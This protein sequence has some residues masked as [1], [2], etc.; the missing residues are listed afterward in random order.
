M[1]RSALA[2]ILVS[3]TAFATPMVGA[4]IGITQDQ[5]NSTQ[6][7]N[8]TYSLFGRI[9][10]I[11]H[12]SAELDLAKPDTNDSTSHRMVTGLAVFDLGDEHWV[13]Q[14]FAGAGVDYATDDYGNSVLGHHFEGG[15]GLEYRA[16]GGFTIGTR[17]HLGGRS[18]DSQDSSGCCVAYVNGQQNI[19]AATQYRTLDMYAGIRF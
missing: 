9:G 15:L 7:P 13:P 4:S 12:L 2:L 10:I 1:V 3:S 14:I 18:I 8:R 16:T 19:L 6:D 17:F 5:T 11:G